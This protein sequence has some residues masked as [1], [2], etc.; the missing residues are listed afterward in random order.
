M[1]ADLPY[2]DRTDSVKDKLRLLETAYAAGNHD[3][4]MSLAESIKDTLSMNRQS[5]LDPGK[6]QSDVDHFVAVERL[7]Q[8]WAKWARGWS[9]CKPIALSRPAGVSQIRCGWL[10]RR[11]WR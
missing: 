4:A 3:L 5:E 11:G 6:P 9:F 1:L 2:I 8:A 7:P 10:P